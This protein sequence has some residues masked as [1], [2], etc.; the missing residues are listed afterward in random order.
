MATMVKQKS[1]LMYGIVPL[2]LVSAAIHFSLFLGAPGM[3]IM[4][5]FN[6]LGYLGLTAAYYLPLPF[7]RDHRK[8]VRY[9]FI[10]YTL[11]TI[12]AWVVI[13][14]RTTIAFIDK[15]AEVVLVAL[16]LLERP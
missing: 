8:L 13:G 14:E 15:A 1:R 11:F 10:G 5:L 12:L 9:V 6:A 7:A 3:M 16:L 4:F 2:A